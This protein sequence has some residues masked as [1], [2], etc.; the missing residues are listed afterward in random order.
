MPNK[1]DPNKIGIT[2]FVDKKV[3]EVAKEILHSYGM[4]ITE[5]LLVALL[6]LIHNDKNEKL[7]ILNEADGRTKK[8]KARIENQKIRRS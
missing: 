5:Y 1:R 2:I 7:K 6:D 8:G 3:K 4:G